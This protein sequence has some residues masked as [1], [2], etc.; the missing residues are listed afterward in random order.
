MICWAVLLWQE[1]TDTCHFAFTEQKLMLLEGD[2]K[3]FMEEV[4]CRQI[5]LKN[6]KNS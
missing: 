5:I 1:L 6:N 2:G 3:D 4:T